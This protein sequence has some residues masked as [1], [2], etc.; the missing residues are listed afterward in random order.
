MADRRG[1]KP[2]LT[3]RQTYIDKWMTSKAQR[4]FS[5]NRKVNAQARRAFT[6]TAKYIVYASYDRIH[7]SA[8]I[9]F[10]IFSIALYVDGMK[11]KYLSVN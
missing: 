4:K 9:N 1:I 5:R 3:H 10:H 2:H 7:N 11:L 8:H 6:R